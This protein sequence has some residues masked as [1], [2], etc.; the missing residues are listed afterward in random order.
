M[1]QQAERAPYPFATLREQ[2]R[3]RI[4]QQNVNK[5]LAG[6]HNV[7]NNTNPNQ[8]DIIA[9][10]EPYVDESYNS[11]GTGWWSPVYPSDH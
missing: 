2:G 5:S 10:Q 6:Q 11:R 3:L 4:W 7:L 1:S 9:L 8:I